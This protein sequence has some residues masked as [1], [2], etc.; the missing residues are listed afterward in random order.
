[1]VHEILVKPFR[2]LSC[3]HLV[4][5]VIVRPERHGNVANQTT[6]EWRHLASK[7][8]GRSAKAIGQTTET[9]ASAG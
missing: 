3:R 2:A 9:G 5:F 8:R 4:N 7:H 6:F 1:M